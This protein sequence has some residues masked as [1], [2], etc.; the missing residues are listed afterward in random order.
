MKSCD[1]IRVG[2]KMPGQD[3][4]RDHAIEFVV[5]GEINLAHAAGA[6]GLFDL[7][8]SELFAD[9]RG[10]G[11]ELLG[12]RTGSRR[13]RGTF[14]KLNGPGLRVEKAQ[15]LLVDDRIAFGTFRDETLA[16]LRRL[17]QCLFEQLVNLF[18]ELWIHWLVS[19]Y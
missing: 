6:E 3:L 5:A 4:E 2:K 16:L 15:H 7:V 13:H 18:P 19:Y 8:R 10:D 11:G 1:A 17:F 9:E 12:Q 14:Q